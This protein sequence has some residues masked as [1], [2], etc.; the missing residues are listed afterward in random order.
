MLRRVRYRR[1]G[2]SSPMSVCVGKGE[3]RGTDA[4]GRSAVSTGTSARR[5]SAPY[6]ERIER[7]D[8]VTSKRQAAQVGQCRQVANAGQIALVEHLEEG[9]QRWC[10]YVRMGRPQS[11][12]AGGCGVHSSRAVWLMRL[13]CAAGHTS[14]DKCGKKPSNL[15]HVGCSLAL[16]L[17]SNMVVSSA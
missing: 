8:A 11:L 10:L 5:P 14:S 17:T 3:V 2:H 1:F 6:H 4:A 16:P 13:A 7:S 12:Q 15:R 9:K